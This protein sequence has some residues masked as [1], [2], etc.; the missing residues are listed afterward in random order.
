MRIVQN[1]KTKFRNPP[2]PT[3]FLSTSTK[4]HQHAPTCTNI[5]QNPPKSTKIYQNPPKPTNGLMFL[6]TYMYVCMYVC[7][8]VYIYIY[9]Y[10]YIYTY[11][12]LSITWLLLGS[13]WGRPG[14]RARRPRAIS[15]SARRRAAPLL[16]HAI[17]RKIR[18]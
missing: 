16:Y 12:H 9:I 14:G 10:I 18:K 8:Y 5:H 15:R 13:S 6:L 3:K 7:M 4:I 17:Y 11:T 2:K 1:P